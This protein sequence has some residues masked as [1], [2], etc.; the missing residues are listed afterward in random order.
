VKYLRD[1]NVLI[2][3]LLPAAEDHAAFYA[4]AAWKSLRAFA[5][6]AQ[7]KLGVVRVSMQAFCY[8]VSVAQQALA[9]MKRS[10]GGCVGV[11][12]SS[13]LAGLF[14]RVPGT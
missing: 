13:V 7:V 11:A 3:G 6:C 1:V 9:E 10:M 8:S 14:R 4:W 5:T 2:A 12:P